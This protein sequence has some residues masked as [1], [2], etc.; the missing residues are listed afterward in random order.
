MSIKIRTSLTLSVSHLVNQCLHVVLV[1]DPH[2]VGRSF[3]SSL[4]LADG[5]G[6]GI[7]DDDFAIGL[8][9]KQDFVAL[10]LIPA[11]DEFQSAQ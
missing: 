6:G 9:K 2:A 11:P 4:R 10:I 3:K 8:L 7:G 5:I 1:F